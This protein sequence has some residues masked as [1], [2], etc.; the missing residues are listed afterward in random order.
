MTQV[1]Y[2]N[3]RCRVRVGGELTDAF[4]VSGGLKQGCPL[5][6]LLFNLA[7]EWIMRQT[8]T[9]VNLGEV[10]CGRLAYADDVDLCG[11]DFQGL[12]HMIGAFR[13]ASS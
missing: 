9:A 2:N 10:S 3:M 1:C 6:T 11:E 7:L 12:Q 13:E 5:S 8:A 4:L